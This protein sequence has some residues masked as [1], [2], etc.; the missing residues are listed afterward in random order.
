M[1]TGHRDMPSCD[2]VSVEVSADSAESCKSGPALQGS[3]E[4]GVRGPGYMIPGQPST[5]CGL[6]QKGTVTRNYSAK[7]IPTGADGGGPT[8][9][10]TPSSWKICAGPAEMSQ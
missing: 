5:G 3:P 9:R 7:S 4:L 6:P 8:P 1:Q 10:G 2:V